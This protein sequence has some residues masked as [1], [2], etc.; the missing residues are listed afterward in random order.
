MTLSPTLA[1]AQTSGSVVVQRELLSEAA[2]ILD[3]EGYGPISS[4]LNAL[5]GAAASSSEGPLERALAFMDFLTS[6]PLLGGEDQLL[7]VSDIQLNAAIELAS[8]QRQIALEGVEKPPPRH[9]GR[10]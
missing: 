4:Q 5:L 2:G 6:D 9:R 7:T 3:C 8:I 10:R 1:V